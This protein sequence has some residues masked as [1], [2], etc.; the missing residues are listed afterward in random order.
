[1]L[2]S[3][4]L[5]LTE[6]GDDANDL[7]Q[8]TFLKALRF[9]EHFER[10]TNMAGWL[11]VIMRNT[12]INEYRKRARNPRVV[13]VDERGGPE[14]EVRSIELIFASPDDAHRDIIG[15]TVFR[16]LDALPVEFR[17]AIILY[18]IEGLDYE[19]IAEALGCPI[20]TVRSRLHRGRELLRL[21][22]G[23]YAERRGYDT[24]VTIPFLREK[25]EKPVT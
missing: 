13:D 4:A 19:E 14:N 11:T 8:E 17:T 23:G 20:G 21:E 18:D 3:F 16:A 2:H 10:G 1:M 25:E 22:L 24:T 15:D 7:T 5:S 9:W 12:Y 6:N